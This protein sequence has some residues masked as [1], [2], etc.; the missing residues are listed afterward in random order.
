MR[1]KAPPPGFT[2]ETKGQVRRRS[3]NR[4]EARATGCT[5]DAHHFHHRK[6]RGHG[7]H[8]V[9]NCLHVC[10]S[11]HGHIHARPAK[12]Y[13]MGWLVHAWQEPRDVLIK[14]GSG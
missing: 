2:E 5:G 6:L 8:S 3:G 1:R 12:S 9:E 10:A 7:D 14:R 11:C 4:C 13:L